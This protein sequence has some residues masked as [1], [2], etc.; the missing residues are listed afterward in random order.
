MQTRKR[1]AKGCPIARCEELR[2]VK[3]TRVADMQLSSELEG[4]Q[5]RERHARYLCSNTVGMIHEWASGKHGLVLQIST[6]FIKL[7]S[8]STGLK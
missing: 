3:T 7:Y 5:Q 4:C 2:I 1:S 8:I 6:F